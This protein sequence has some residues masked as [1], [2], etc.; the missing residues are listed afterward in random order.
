MRKSDAASRFHGSVAKVQ[1]KEGL[2]YESWGLRVQAA[3]PETM[4]FLIVEFLQPR[5]SPETCKSEALTV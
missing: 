3:G 4:F 5:R 2:G 1:G